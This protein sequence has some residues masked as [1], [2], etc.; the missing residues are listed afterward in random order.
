MVRRDGVPETY[1]RKE[2]DPT[3][4]GR[5]EES[6]R[7][8]LTAGSRRSKVDFTVEEVLGKG[9]MGTTSSLGGRM[10]WGY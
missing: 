2:T 5:E 3:G 8:T 9:S 4:E 10:E 1:T 7:G 6:E